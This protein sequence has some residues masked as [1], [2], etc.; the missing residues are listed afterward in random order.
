MSS[1]VG[2]PAVE[3]WTCAMAS[4]RDEEHRRRGVVVPL[5]LHVAATVGASAAGYL[6]GHLVGGRRLARGPHG[7]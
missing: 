1:G 2:D 4:V 5:V 6:G 3:Y 7:R